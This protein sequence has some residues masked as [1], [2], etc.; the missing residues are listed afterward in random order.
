MNG[1]DQDSEDQKCFNCASVRLGE[2]VIDDES[3]RQDV[4][5]L[6]ALQSDFVSNTGGARTIHTEDL[7]RDRIKKC[8]TKMRMSITGA[9]AGEQLLVVSGTGDIIGEDLIEGQSWTIGV[10][11][12]V[13]VGVVLLSCA[14]TV[15]SSHL[16]TEGHVTR[17]PEVAREPSCVTPRSM[18][19]D[20][21][22]RM[23]VRTWNLSW[24][25]GD[26][27][28]QLMVLLAR[29]C[30]DTLLQFLRH[31]AIMSEDQTMCSCNH[32][33]CSGFFQLGTD[34]DDYLYGSRVAHD[35]NTELIEYTSG[36]HHSQNKIVTE[37]QVAM[38][39]TRGI[40]LR[41]KLKSGLMRVTRWRRC[42]GTMRLREFIVGSAELFFEARLRQVLA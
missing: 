27:L 20:I 26:Q 15:H 40:E 42:H 14:S 3:A 25:S 32:R 17:E 5:S 30:R 36:A 24:D 41:E 33:V 4:S 37:P 6:S 16:P 13:P 28:W 19:A 38:K 21:I 12:L 10:V 8:V 18:Q 1:T 2:Y 23:R 31:I 9:W 7:D 35:W 22:N 29:Y 39:E 34:C 11:L